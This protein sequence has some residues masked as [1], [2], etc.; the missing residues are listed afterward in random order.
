MD[1]P[2]TAQIPILPS[3]PEPPEPRVKTRSPNT[4]KSPPNTKDA[5]VSQ[6]PVQKQGQTAKPEQKQAQK[7][8]PEG[9]KSTTKAERRALQEKQRAEKAAAKGAEVCF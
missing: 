8:K 9:G 1:S 2:S 6:P 4:V 7:A 5:N 3:V